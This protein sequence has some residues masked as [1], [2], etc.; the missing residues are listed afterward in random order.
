MREDDVHLSYLPLPHV[1]D[2]CMCNTIIY[3]A[4]AIYFYNG[5]NLKLKQ[6]LAD[7]RPTVFGSVPRLYN[8]FYDAIT[9]GINNA[10]FIK[11]FL[12]NWAI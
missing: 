7:V 10:S 2:R 8:K 4:G 3:N 11:K 9:G 12:G 1:F 6:D 5:D